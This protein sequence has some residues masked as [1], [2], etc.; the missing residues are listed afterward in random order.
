MNKKQLELI[1]RPFRAFPLLWLLTFKLVEKFNRFFSSKGDHNYFD[2]SRFSWAKDLEANVEK[3][4]SELN[5][6]LYEE[7]LPD[8][9]EVDVNWKG[10]I[11]DNR[12]KS[13]FFIGY[14]KVIEEN[15]A[16][17]PVTANLVKAIPGINTAF[18]S[19]LQ[20]GAVIPPHRGPYN[21]VLTYHLGVKIPKE[22]KSCSL[23]VDR[24]LRPWEF[25]KSVIFD[26]SY[27]HAVKNDTDEVRVVLMVNFVRPLPWPF[28]A[29]N[30]KMIDALT[31]LPFVDRGYEKLVNSSF[32][33][34]EK[35][36]ES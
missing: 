34:N 28:N 18:F 9:H 26:D 35:L 23:S 16:K 15:C 29:L 1:P 12:W 11:D 33:N 3:I 36:N 2:T 22:Y 5:D 21:G 30:R 6:V 20:P 8:V 32:E 4:Q 10:T 24:E 14:G 17:C 7:V 25:G 19:V 27:I 13:F 31:S